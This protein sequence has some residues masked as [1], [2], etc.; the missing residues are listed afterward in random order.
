MLPYVSPWADDELSLFRENVARF[1]ETEMVPHDATWRRQHTVGKEIWR[2]AGEMLVIMT[3]SIGIQFVVSTLSPA[4]AATGHNRLGAAWKLGAFLVTFTVFA[5]MPSE[6]RP[7][8]VL[9]ALSM[10]NVVLYVLYY[11]CIWYAVRSR[12]GFA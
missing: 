9:V 6:S 10:T 8:G 12:A 3:P 2:K 5:S 1:V 11:S 4:L 7:D